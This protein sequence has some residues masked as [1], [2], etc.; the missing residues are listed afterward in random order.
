LGVNYVNYLH[1]VVQ[2]NALFNQWMTN[3]ISSWSAN[4]PLFLMD[5]VFQNT[6]YNEGFNFHVEIETNNRIRIDIKKTANLTEPWK[7]RTKLRLKL[8]PNE[9]FMGF[10]ERLEGVAFRGKKMLKC[11]FIYLL[12]AMVYF[13]TKIRVVHLIWGKAISISTKLRFGIK[14]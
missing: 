9:Y 13:L 3:T 6:F 11:L 2:D 14:N 7:Y 1:L 12:A 5:A 4:D 8:Y 10:G